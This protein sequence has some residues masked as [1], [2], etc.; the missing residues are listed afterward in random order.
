MERK[1]VTGFLC[2][3]FVTALVG[4]KAVLAKDTGGKNLGRVEGCGLSVR[5]RM[6]EDGKECMY[7]VR[8]GFVLARALYGGT[9]GE[10]TDYDIYR[11]KDGK[12]ELF[13]SHPPES[14][15]NKE[16]TYHS[17]HDSTYVSNLVYHDGFL[18]YSLLY[19]KNYG[20]GDSL[21]KPQYIYR[22]P[23]QGGEPEELALSYNTFHIYDGKIYYRTVRILEGEESSVEELYWRM[24]PDG[25]GK[26]VVYRRKTG[27][28]SQFAPRMFTV[29]D[30][31]LYA[32]YKDE[33]VIKI[34]GINLETGDK[35]LFTVEN[36]VERLYYEDGYLYFYARDKDEYN[37][38]NI[39]RINTV[40]GERETVVRGLGDSDDVW[41]EN[42]YL[43]YTKPEII[44]GGKKEIYCLNILNMDTGQRV[45]EDLGEVTDRTFTM[46][47]AVAGNDLLCETRSCQQEKY[48]GKEEIK[49]F[50]YG[51]RG[52]GK[53]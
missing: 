40:S 15:N 31:Y 49:R 14:V 21:Y 36:D 50:K 52:E 18:Y 11:L 38:N 41:M 20:E 32:G 47:L 29:G 7:A 48:D 53:Y 46:Y 1:I 6:V 39:V 43:Y 28:P 4:S 25:K 34:T 10:E 30:G 2:M 8:D 16:I 23:E 27:P 22:M 24:E 5:G 26:Q 17:Y 35:C 51:A 19:E 9:G 42:G 37:K 45:T 12:W 13:V 33:E 3:L 44:A